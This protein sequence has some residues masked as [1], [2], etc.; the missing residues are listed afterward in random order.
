L[1]FNSLEFIFIFLPITL[2]GFFLLGELNDR[3]AVSWLVLC[4]LFFY[5]WWNPVYLL[6]IL[7]SILVNYTFGVMLVK[8]EKQKTR[9]VLLILG[10]I[11]NLVLLG[12]FKYAN[13]FVEQ[14]NLAIGS[15]FYLGKILLPLAISFFTFQQISY[16]VDAYRAETKESN[17]LNY[18]LFVTFFPQLIA[19]PIVHH[20]EM[21][22]QFG[23]KG[24]CKFNY[25][26]ISIGLAI[27]IVGLF[28]KVIL[29]DGIAIYATPVFN[30]A[31]AEAVLTFFE[32][33]C[34][35]F[36]YTLQLYFDFSGY[37]D[38][39]IGIAYMFG[40]KLPINFNSPYKATSIIDFWRRWHITLSRFLRDYL[41]IALGGDRKGV[42]R[43]YVNLFL[44]MLLGGI[45]H[46]AGWTFV[47]WGMLHGFY[48]VIN[49]V[50]RKL[51]RDI[52][53]WPDGIGKIELTLYRVLTLLAVV[54]SWVYFRAETVSG[55]N[56]IMLTMFGFHGIALPSG[57]ETKVGAF[58]LQLKNWGFAF[59]GMFGS[60]SA[61][62][63]EGIKWI[64]LLFFVTLLFPN[65][66]QII[67]H[68][69]SPQ[70]AIIAR[71]PLVSGLVSAIG[72]YYVF[73]NLREDSEFLYFNF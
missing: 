14:V 41:Y 24:I 4:S 54:I 68:N 11:V 44:T 22:P 48:L 63:R 1:L 40:I 5:G 34:G 60:L 20:K 57:L 32:S 45:W 50:W 52:F 46:G 66:Q 29:A 26:H 8:E 25:E 42:V 58:A 70:S 28:K 73:I 49:H 67:N 15:S 55:A 23:M 65:T 51:R 56:H 33:W 37:S 35:A 39:A 16:L 31:E 17:F 59:N 21:L 36:A 61:D 64:V 38:M 6:L 43:R 62:L 7:F 18:C 2:L 3:I 19:G 10:I 13:F 69:L 12:Y 27:F 47:C 72:L 9:K 71:K 53:I 30:A